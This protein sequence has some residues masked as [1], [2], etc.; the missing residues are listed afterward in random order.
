MRTEHK[1]LFRFVLQR[2]YRVWQ[3]EKLKATVEIH[4]IY[5]KFAIALAADINMLPG[6]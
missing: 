1:V 2:F 4:D 5:R 3:T 6:Y